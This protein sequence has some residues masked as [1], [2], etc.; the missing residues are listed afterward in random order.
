MTVIRLAV[1]VYILMC[2]ILSAF[3]LLMLVGRDNINFEKL[4]VQWDLMLHYKQ[5]YKKNYVFAVETSS[6][7]IFT[8]NLYCDMLKFSIKLLC[9]KS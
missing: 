2:K 5:E 3:L 4:E 8:K 7:L 9:L 1:K 6:S